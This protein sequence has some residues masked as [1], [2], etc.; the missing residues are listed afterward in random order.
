MNAQH[1][2]VTLEIKFILEKRYSQIYITALLYI[3]L[4]RVNNTGKASSKIVVFK[5]N[6]H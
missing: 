5:P 1:F 4:Y 3:K 2:Y 6:R